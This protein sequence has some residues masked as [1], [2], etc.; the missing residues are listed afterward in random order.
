MDCPSCKYPD[1]KVIRSN[2]DANDIVN[3]RR[4]CIRCGIRVNTQERMK[5]S[6]KGKDKHVLIA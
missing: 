5:E 3:R 4:Q 1:M 6:A 2:Y